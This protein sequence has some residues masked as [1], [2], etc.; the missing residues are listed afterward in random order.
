[1]GDLHIWL[2]HFLFLLIVNLDALHWAEGWNNHDLTQCNFH[3]ESPRF[4]YFFGNLAA[5][6]YNTAPLQPIVEDLPAAD[7]EDIDTYG[8]DWK[9]MDHPD[10]RHHQATH[11]I[12]ADANLTDVRTTYTAHFN[13]VEVLDVVC[14]LHPNEVEDLKAQLL[15]LSFVNNRSMD[16]Q[17]LVWINAL[18]IVEQIV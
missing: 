5:G 10:I 6:N 7:E 3:V 15:L 1:N 8:I 14:A 17:R 9:E 11:N 12:N 18:N 4:L 13:H 2:V 16:V